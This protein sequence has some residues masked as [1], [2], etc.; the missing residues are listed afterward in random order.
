MSVIDIYNR[1]LDLTKTTNYMGP[2]RLIK[3]GVLMKYK[4]GRRL[5]AFLCNDMLILT[6]EG[7]NRL[8]KMVELS[9]LVNL[10]TDE[11]T[12]KLGLS[13]FNSTKLR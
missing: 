7:V 2:R 1:R 13:R 4:S 10:A 9:L 11:L 12:C 6:D 3:E 8:Y 5:C